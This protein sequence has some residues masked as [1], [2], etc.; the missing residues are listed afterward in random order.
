[1]KKACILEAVDN[2]KL[3]KGLKPL[4]ISVLKYQTFFNKI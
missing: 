2:D 1:M 4:K 3:G